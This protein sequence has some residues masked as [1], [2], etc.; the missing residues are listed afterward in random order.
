MGEGGKLTVKQL[1][2]QCDF[3]IQL[4]QQKASGSQSNET[5]GFM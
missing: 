1:R 2:W 3:W 4:A 5:S